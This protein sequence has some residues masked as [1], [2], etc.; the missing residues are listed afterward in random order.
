MHLQKSFS[1]PLYF[2]TWSEFDRQEIELIKNAERY[3]A[4]SGKDAQKSQILPTER[5]ASSFSISEQ[6]ANRATM[7]F[8]SSPSFENQSPASRSLALWAS[9]MLSAFI[10]N[11]DASYASMRPKL[12]SCWVS[13]YAV[14]CHHRPH[15]HPL[16]DFSS[17]FCVSRQNLVSEEGLL[18]FHDPRGPVGMYFSSAP[19]F[20]SDTLS[21]NLAPGSLVLFPSWLRHSVTPVLSQDARRIT[22]SCN[23]DL[24]AD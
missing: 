20:T 24:S 6:V 7:K 12:T 5:D 21:I 16:S 22:V 14:G 11:L 8:E 17:V 3:L 4:A 2:A 18:D 23:F 13:L 9:E 15:I 19:I 10:T 1:T